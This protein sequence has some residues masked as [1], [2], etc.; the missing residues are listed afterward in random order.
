[1]LI[2]IC[3]ATIEWRG[4]PCPSDLRPF[5]VEG[6]AGE[7]ALVVDARRVDEL[8]AAPEP[9]YAIGVTAV[10]HEGG[11]LVGWNV[12]EGFE[13]GSARLALD[14]RRAT[15]LMGPGT[16]ECSVMNM[17]ML[18]LLPAVSR[19]S[20]LLMHASL[21]EW[22]GRAVAFTAPSGTGK[23]TQA[24]LW[25]D[26]LG[27]EIMNGDRA[28]LRRAASG[29]WTAYG[30]PWAGSSPYVR[31]VSAP[32]AAVVVLEQAPENR[33]R[34]LRPAETL[35]H[36]YNNLR[37][38]LWDEG[39]CADSLASFDALAREVPVY[40]LSCRPDE[41]AVRTARDAVFEGV[42]DDAG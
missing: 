30:S 33:I 24:D 32:L 11:S 41:G 16:W 21:V 18:A 7:P 37:Y 15:I 9:E 40:L 10:S 42:P 3:G 14:G 4:E 23:S 29:A 31:N 27:A 19:D 25:H 2:G 22:E 13:E 38:P 28:F 26:V 1:M 17:L 35:P 36:L 5:V 34:R 12:Y 8:P 6:A 20:S 39:A